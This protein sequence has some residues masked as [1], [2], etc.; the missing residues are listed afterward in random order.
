MFLQRT[1]ESYSLLVIKYPYEPRHDKTNKMSVRPAKTQISL[2]IRPVWSESSLCAQWVAMDPRFLHADSE[3][4]DQT[5]RMPRLIWVVA[6]GTLTLLVLSCRGSYDLFLWSNNG[7][8]N[9]L[10]G[11]VPGEDVNISG[12]A[13][14]CDLK[15]SH[16]WSW[17]CHPWPV[18]SLLRH[19]QCGTNRHNRHTGPADRKQI[20]ETGKLCLLTTDRKFSS[21]LHTNICCGYPLE[22]PHWQAIPMS[23]HNICLLWK[24]ISLSSQWIC[25]W[26]N[27]WS[28]EK[29]IFFF[30]I[31]RV[32]KSV[33]RFKNLMTHEDF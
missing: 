7:S 6:W 8:W 23:T 24:I 5:G 2:G 31:H 22:S 9:C 32:M 18:Y 15:Y 21:V 13:L 1:E 28:H 12:T 3:D 33:G 16:N 30:R 20:S 10:D 29:I 4:S 19:T 14:S 17:H 26:E 11:A 25:W 27:K